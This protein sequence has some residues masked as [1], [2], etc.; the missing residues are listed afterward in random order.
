MPRALP[1]RI[2]LALLV[3]VFA[4]APLAGRA[5]TAIVAKA[6]FG[7]PTLGNSLALINRRSG[8]RLVL[9]GP[10]P[11][12][13]VC[14]EVGTGTSI[15]SVNV[16]G[17]DLDGDLLVDDGINLRS[18][19]CS[20]RRH[21]ARHSMCGFG[22]ISRNSGQNAAWIPYAPNDPERQGVLAR[23][24]SVRCGFTGRWCRFRTGSVPAERRC[25][26]EAEDPQ[27][28]SQR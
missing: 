3:S 6:F 28:C 27:Q 4:S 26:S 18:P 23:R 25:R 14:T 9:S 12:S 24:S 19:A 22:W 16:I 10:G 1:T 20:A 11:V 13:G 15:A 2:R 5:A 8:D 7:C 17:E 21:C